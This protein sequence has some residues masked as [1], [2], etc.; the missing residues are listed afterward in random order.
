MILAV[1]VCARYIYGA[2]QRIHF[3]PRTPQ[4]IP[5]TADEVIPPIEPIADNDFVQRECARLGGSIELA[6]I[7]SRAPVAQLDRA[8][9]F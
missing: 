1:L 3:D 2:P 8:P 9:A 5:L 7:D 6:T 4:T